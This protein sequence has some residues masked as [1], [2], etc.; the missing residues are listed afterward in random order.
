MRRIDPCLFGC[1]VR[2]RV[3]LELEVFGVVP[4]CRTQTDQKYW[5]KRTLKHC[6]TQE[7]REAAWLPCL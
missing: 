1:T 5:K 7:A 6:L 3:V 2:G 4:Q